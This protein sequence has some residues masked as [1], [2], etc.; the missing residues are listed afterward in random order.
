VPVCV[1]IGCMCVC[2]C[3]CVCVCTCV[4]ARGWHQM[5]FLSLHGLVF[6]TVSLW[7]WNVTVQ[8]G[9]PASE[10]QGFPCICVPSSELHGHTDKPGLL[11]RSS[12]L[13]DRH[14]T[15]LRAESPPQLYSHIS[16]FFFF[17]KDLFIIICKYTVVVFR[18]SRGGSQISLQMV[19]SH[20][21]V[22]GIWTLNLWKSSRV[23]LPTEPSHQ[24]YSHISWAS[25]FLHIRGRKWLLHPLWVPVCWTQAV[26][27]LPL[28]QVAGLEGSIQMWNWE[29]AP[30]WTRDYTVIAC[31]WKT[32][33]FSQRKPVSG[34]CQE[35][36][37]QSEE[38]G[39]EGRV[40]LSWPLF[41][42]SDLT[43]H[44]SHSPIRGAVEDWRDCKTQD[45]YSDATLLRQEDT[46][47]GEWSRPSLV[48]ETHLCLP[49]PMGTTARLPSSSVQ[50]VHCPV[51]L[52]GTG[53]RQPHF[54]AV[55][56]L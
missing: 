22:A 43:I 32:S 8:L 50:T 4:Q 1:Y 56:G 16:F 7:I 2:V 11:G 35:Q 46:G 18:H 55:L 29:A 19:V 15:T 36:A 30:L 53:K 6:E 25:F 24:P 31:L 45:H 26:W 33:G 44:T 49:S 3:V 28:L 47:D 14:F 48:S 10:L 42:I 5:S 12:C 51:K 52:E 40:E 34:I 13:W 9:C 37:R 17:F 54:C 21:V 20:H 27:E 38:R 41:W 39:R 23:L